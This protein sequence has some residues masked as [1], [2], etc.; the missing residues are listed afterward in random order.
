MC[1]VLTFVT[2]C[3]LNSDT[4]KHQAALHFG[5]AHQR[6]MRKHNE[7]RRLILDL[8]QLL[9]DFANLKLAE[10]IKQRFLISLPTNIC[11]QQRRGID[12]KGLAWNSGKLVSHGVAIVREKSNP[13][14]RR[15][16]SGKPA[17]CNFLTAVATMSSI[18]PA[19][20]NEGT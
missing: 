3:V 7:A 6:N 17:A 16:F 1:I 14:T 15:V 10:L 4:F 2:T 20:N 18:G 11:V 9:L 13:R 5:A 19:G 12:R 8:S